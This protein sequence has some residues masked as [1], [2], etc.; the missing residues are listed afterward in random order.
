M[1]I[2]PSPRLSQSASETLP[3]PGFYTETLTKFES[4]S[5]YIP[6]WIE[7]HRT[8]TTNPGKSI[9]PLNDD[10]KALYHALTKAFVGEFVGGAE[11]GGESANV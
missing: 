9:D 3:N 8:K 4:P 5:A 2:H 7:L 1:I 11:A 10:E 6:V